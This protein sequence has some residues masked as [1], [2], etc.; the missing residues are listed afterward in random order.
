MYIWRVAPVLPRILAYVPIH[1][2]PYTVQK[3]VV[4]MVSKGVTREV[5]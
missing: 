5:Q 4:G 2:A 1:L 3:A